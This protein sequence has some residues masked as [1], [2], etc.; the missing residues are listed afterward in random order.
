MKGIIKAVAKEPKTYN[1][2]TTL[3]VMGGNDGYKLKGD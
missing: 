1:G 2:I 3:G